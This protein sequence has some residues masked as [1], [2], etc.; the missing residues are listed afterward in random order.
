MVH[1]KEQWATLILESDSKDRKPPT[2]RGRVFGAQKSVSG[3]VG[4]KMADLY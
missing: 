1:V 4:K 2:F 3:E